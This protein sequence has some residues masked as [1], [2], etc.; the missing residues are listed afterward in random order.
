MLSDIYIFLF[1]PTHLE[2]PPFI[3]FIGQ[4]SVDLWL[5]HTHLLTVLGHLHATD[6]H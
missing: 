3:S 1:L 2:T 5:L 6:T 4:V